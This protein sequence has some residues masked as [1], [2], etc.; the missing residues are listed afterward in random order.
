MIGM[1]TVHKGIAHI[2]AG[3]N[4]YFGVAAFE[5]GKCVFIVDVRSGSDRVATCRM[6]EVTASASKLCAA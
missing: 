5:C 3:V 1:L 6:C 2:T 4:K